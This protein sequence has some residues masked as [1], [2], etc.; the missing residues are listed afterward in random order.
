MY[1]RNARADATKNMKNDSGGRPSG[2]GNENYLSGRLPRKLQW[3][4]FRRWDRNHR[5][6]NK[7]D[8]GRLTAQK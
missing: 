4:G 3:I 8:F 2:N 1:N 5:D 6:M 7:L